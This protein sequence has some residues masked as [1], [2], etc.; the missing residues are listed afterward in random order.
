MQMLSQGKEFSKRGNRKLTNRSCYVADIITIGKLTDPGKEMFIAKVK[1]KVKVKLSLLRP[2]FL[3]NIGNK[4]KS[5]MESKPA[6][7]K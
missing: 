5:H 1:V 7:R 3:R 4:L 2:V 6:F